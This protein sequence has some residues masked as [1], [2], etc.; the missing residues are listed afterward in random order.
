MMTEERVCGEDLLPGGGVEM[1]PNLALTRLDSFKVET[2][3]RSG[4]AFHISVSASFH[5]VNT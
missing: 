4:S 1:R 2:M 3:Q 5:Q